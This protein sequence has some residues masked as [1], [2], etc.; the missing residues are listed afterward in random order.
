M[1]PGDASAL[2]CTAHQLWKQSYI[3][4]SALLSLC[5]LSIY[6][7][8]KHSSTTADDGYPPAYT[9][10]YTAPWSLDPSPP[11]PTT[12]EAAHDARAQSSVLVECRHGA[13]EKFASDST[14]AQESQF[15][16]LP[17][18]PEQ[19][20]GCDDGHIHDLVVRQVMAKE[21]QRE[22]KPYETG[23]KDRA[24]LVK[25][26]ARALVKTQ[27]WNGKEMEGPE[28]RKE[29]GRSWFGGSWAREVQGHG[30]L[31]E[32]D[33]VECGRGKG[34]GKVID[35]EK[36]KKLY[37]LQQKIDELKQR[38][39]GKK[40]HDS[41][42]PPGLDKYTVQY[43]PELELVHRKENISIESPSPRALLRHSDPVI[44]PPRPTSPL[45]YGRHGTAVQQ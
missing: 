13:D 11:Y 8:S 26:R 21:T 32:Q 24:E 4:P 44:L 33:E 29:N 10:L 20:R 27:K 7:L 16:P 34:V 6:P 19:P 35:W 25:D 23:V 28:G 3:T 31:G 17:P 30:R 42:L 1:R 2:V 45:P 15:L 14:A 41:N 9:P 36:E 22:W 5:Q 40:V 43:Q 39:K 37:R 12:W 18:A 38:W